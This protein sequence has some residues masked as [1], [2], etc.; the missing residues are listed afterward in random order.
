MLLPRLTGREGILQ[1]MLI[2]FVDSR[3]R[4]IVKL[5]IDDDIVKALKLSG[6][7]LELFNGISG[8]PPINT[9]G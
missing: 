8:T 1:G 2:K 5:T 7:L 9:I 4:D 6:K 3:L